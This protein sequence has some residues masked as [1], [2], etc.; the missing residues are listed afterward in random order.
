MNAFVLEG[1]ATDEVD[2]GKTPEMTSRADGKLRSA[3]HSDRDFE[4]RPLSFCL[5]THI[6][7][8]LSSTVL[9]NFDTTSELVL[10]E[11]PLPSEENRIP[12]STE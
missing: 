12:F 7:P 10:L 11:P 6:C 9:L 3:N 5:H 2:E 1:R 8:S 4:R